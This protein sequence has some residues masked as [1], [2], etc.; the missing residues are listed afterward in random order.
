LAYVVLRRT[1]TA[2]AALPR[3]IPASELWSLTTRVI[4]EFVP[5]KRTP[6]LVLPLIGEPAWDTW[7]LLMVIC[8]PD[9]TLMP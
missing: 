7:M 6:Y 5:S 3:K 9:L 2:V 8:E 4:N 1:T